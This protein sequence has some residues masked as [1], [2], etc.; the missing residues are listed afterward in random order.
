ML[1][2]L[3]LMSLLNECEKRIMYVTSRECLTK[4]AYTYIEQNSH[5]IGYEVIPIKA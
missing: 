3:I 2:N 5:I 4:G 1:E